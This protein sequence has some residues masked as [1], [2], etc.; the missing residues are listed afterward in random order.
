MRKIR[1]TT[2]PRQYKNSGQHA[3]QVARFTFTGEIRKADN[4]PFTAGGDIGGLQVKSARATICKGFDLDKHLEMDGATCYGYVTDTFEFIYIMTPTEYRE[5]A[6]TFG[7][8][9]TDSKANGGGGK[10]RFRY[11]TD[12]MRK[13]LEEKIL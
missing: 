8:R 7:T 1:L 11:E 5:F 9:T 12:I 6:L 10:L 13:W 4:K 2:I 3:E